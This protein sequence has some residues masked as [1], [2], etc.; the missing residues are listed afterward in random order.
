MSIDR[1][2]SSARDPVALQLPRVVF[3]S[4]SL[5]NLYKATSNEQKL[6][7]VKEWLQNGSPNLVI[8]TAGK[9]GAGLALECIG[10]S[11]RALGVDPADVIINNKLGWYRTALTTPE[12]TF[13]P[14]AWV[15]IEHDAEQRI[16]RQGILDCWEQ[17]CELL[18]EP[19]RPQMVSV[20][21]PDEY[22]AAA[23][24]DADRDRRRSDMLEAYKALAELRDAGETR[25]IGVGAKDW[26]VAR[27][28][29]QIVQLDW[30]MIANSLTVLTHPAELVS[31]LDN[32]HSQGV[33]VIN[34]AVF[35]AGF[36]IGGE[37]FNY[38][39][40]SAEDAADRKLFDWRTRFFDLC[41]RHEV[42]P[43]AACI[44]FG[45]S[46]PSVR[47]VAL[48]T[49]NP[50]RIAGN[51]AMAAVQLPDGFWREAKQQRLIDPEYRHVG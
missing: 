22:L 30:V 4:S 16:S 17:G 11:L 40:V 24:D 9:Y 42:D 47:S 39:R 6:A 23:L 15:A 20:H 44:R 21:D 5:G 8:D 34:S 14:G 31:W 51:V 33:A 2:E 1:P 36:L 48:G 41:G 3:G 43:V 12:P 28:V 7:I 45:L 19:Y 27:Q 50:A 26:K 25:Y 10:N 29:S 13:E 49:S 32:L 38:R 46:P 37:F 18:G 35:N